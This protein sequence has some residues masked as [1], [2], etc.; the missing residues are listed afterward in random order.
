MKE[1]KDFN[2]HTGALL[3]SKPA[4]KAYEDGWSGTFGKL[5]AFCC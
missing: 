1:Y 5:C 3:V 2:E 4:T